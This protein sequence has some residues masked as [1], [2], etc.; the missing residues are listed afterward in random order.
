MMD[1]TKLIVFFSIFLFLSLVSVTFAQE[2][3]SPT[4]IVSSAP[5]V[6]GKPPKIT[7]PIAELG[8]CA[9]PSTC[10]S[11]CDIEANRDACIAFAKK[12]GFFKQPQKPN[13][14]TI[15]NAA[16]TE[17]G[18]NSAEA[19][20]QFCSQEENR[21][22]CKAFAEKYKLGGPKQNP[23]S[24]PIL[25]K[26]KEILGC[27]SE[28]T[29]KAMCQLPENQQKCSDFAKQAGIGGGVRRVGPGGCTSEETCRAYCQGH[30]D[31][32]KQF[33]EQMRA[34]GS[35]MMHEGVN[36]QQAEQLKEKF[37]R[38]NPDRCPNGVGGPINTQGF[39]K[40]NPQKCQGAREYN[41][42]TPLQRPQ[43][44]GP[45]PREYNQ[46]FA[47]RP[48]EGENRGGGEFTNQPPP[49]GEIHSTTG[50][51]GAQTGPSLLDSFIIWLHNTL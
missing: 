13:M 1:K 46:Q 49:P 40:D 29:C 19:C 33:S 17:L 24:R 37:C 8:N 22:K 9:S 18:C 20:K 7:F 43:G 45:G 36:N 6:T 5:T 42:G 39:C 38:E 35:A 26:A 16:K 48:R 25:E 12:Q 32:C 30:M 34:S 23:G 44:T 11:Y 51:Q 15:I 10:K 50:V 14:D 3:L 47:P 41:Q 27:T 21:D 2:T 28:A 31:E 4:P